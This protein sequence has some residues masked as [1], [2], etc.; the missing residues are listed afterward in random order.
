[1]VV[2][3]HDFFLSCPN[4]GH[5]DF[6]RSAICEL[7]PLSAA[8][9]LAN[10]DK[11]HYG[12]KLWR[13]ARHKTRETLFDFQT[14]PATVLA[15]H[16]AMAPL[17]ELGGIPSRSVRVLRNP[18]TPW[19]TRRVEAERNQSLLYVGRLE[20]DKGVDALA[21]AANRLGAHLK[22]VGDGPLRSVLPGLCPDIELLGRQPPE[23]IGAIARTARIAVLPTRV[24]ET[25]GMV[26]LEA[27]ISGLP[28]VCSQSASIADELMSIGVGLS[29]AGD[30]P[31]AL[32][33]ALATL[34][35]DD[36]TIET[37]SRSGFG[38]ARRLAPTEDHWGT[39]LVDIYG[40]TLARS[41]HPNRSTRTGRLAPALNS[42]LT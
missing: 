31:D 26:A 9:L 11:R 12:H 4:G 34:L 42:E 22:V 20:L 8:C 29:Y 19:S 41:L 30:H 32:A 7:K 14:M 18:V 21:I 33:E 16:E 37:M 2:S 40:Q 38:Q 23:A 24:R 28:V 39:Q 25:F 36:A 1:M 5:F 6:N 3:A 15:V 13:V 10:C 27:A 17:L 35:G